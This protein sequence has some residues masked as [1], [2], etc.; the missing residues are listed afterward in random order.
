MR[1]FNK[2]H[3]IALPRCA[4]VSVC[5]ALGALGIRIA[6]LGRIF[7]EDTPE[8]HNPAR[9]IR[10]HEQITAGDFDLE[11]LREC[12]GLAD[13]PACI[14][15][16]FAALD[17]RY[18]G[19][20]F[21]NVRRDGDLGAWVQ[22]AERQFVGLQLI[23]T[24]RGSTPQDRAFM[25]V[26]ADFRR[27]TFGRS[28]FDADVFRR[29]YE[30][31]QREIERYF[32]GRQGVLLDVADITLLQKQG[33]ELLCGF[34]GCTA[35]AIPFPHRDDHSEAP[36]RAFLEALRRGEIRSQTGI[37]PADATACSPAA[38]DR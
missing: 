28:E 23:K 32:A 3:V 13:Y 19:S 10:L 38:E 16:V 26:M 14:P 22:S 30:R 1:D 7:G 6:H 8:H 27:M 12:D 18:P 11:I 34:L 20:L 25:R 4:T 24:G 9:L 37:T 29:A 21:I 36:R 2:V 31:H 5:D 33:I 35:P 17:R 15:E